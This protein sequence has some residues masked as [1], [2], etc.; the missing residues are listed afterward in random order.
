MVDESFHKLAAVPAF[1]AGS[2]PRWV[3]L[4]IFH[5]PWVAAHA[6]TK[7]LLASCVSLGLGVRCRRLE[8]AA[9]SL[10]QLCATLGS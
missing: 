2:L 7:A 8:V 6:S 9:S 10:V 4:G 5:R 3:T 1:Q